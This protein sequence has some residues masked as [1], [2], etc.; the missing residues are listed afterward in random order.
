MST[1]TRDEHVLAVVTAPARA[2]DDRTDDGWA[3]TGAAI[4]PGAPFRPAARG[5]QALRWAVEGTGQ[6]RCRPCP[7]APSAAA[8]RCSTAPG[9]PRSERRLHEQGSHGLD[10]VATAR[11][12]LASETLALPSAG[13]ERREALRLLLIARRSAVDVRRAALTQLRGRDRHCSRPSSRRAAGAAGRKAAR[14]LAATSAARARS[15][16]DELADAARAARS[17]PPDRSR[18]T[19]QAAGELEREILTHVRALAPQAARPAR[20]RPDRRS[21]TAGRLV[22][23]RPAPLRSRLR[24]P[25]RRRAAPPA[26]SGQTTRHRLSRGGD[27]QLNRALH[28]I[29]LHR[30]QH[31][32]ATQAYIAKRLAE[33][34]T[35]QE[36]NA[37]AEAL[38][39]P[40]PLPTTPNTSR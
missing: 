4:R 31:D 9:A 34:K 14:P 3:R 19:G 5:R 27:R 24:R 30:R 35:H 16:P 32:P 29:V 12:A 36:S 39:R 2:W 22:T 10:A 11:A 21:A 38:P 40:P 25:R 6:L 23:P 37:L 7:R 20:R 1:P 18:A 8:R 13:G 33:G 28:T 26:S 15:C 17:R